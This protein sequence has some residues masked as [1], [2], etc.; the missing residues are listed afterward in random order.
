MP[1]WAHVD[2]L[3]ASAAFWVASQCRQ[4][5]ANSATALVGSIGTYLTLYDMSGKADKDGVKALHFATGPLKGA[6]APGTEVTAD[7]KAYF[8]GLVDAGQAVFDAAV[9]AGRH[10]SA[11]QLAAVKSGGV[12]PARDAIRLGLV[13]GIQSFDQTLAQLQAS[14]ARAA[15]R[16]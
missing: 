16:A 14:A 1:V 4:V 11:A 6:A 9:K 2:D 5:W 10:L 12:F 8:Q 3:C 13:D 7:Q 15:A